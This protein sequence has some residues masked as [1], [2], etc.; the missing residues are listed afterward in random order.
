MNWLYIAGGAAVIVFAFLVTLLST[1]MAALVARRFGFIDIPRLHKAHAKPTPLLGGC[2]IFVAVLGPMLFALALVRVWASTGWPDFIPER[3]AMHIPGA[4]EKAPLAV[5]ILFGALVL[6]V[7][8]IFD[9]R[10]AMGPFLKLTVQVLVAAFVVIVLNVRV[11]TMVDPLTILGLHVGQ[12]LSYIASILWIVTITNAFNFLDNMDG[13]SAGVAAIC[14]A[15]LLAAAASIG[16][17]FVTAWLCLLLGALLGFLV[18]NFPP[19]KIFMGDSGSLVVGY[20]MA[21]LSCLTTYV[22]RNQPYELYAVFVPVVLLA[23]PMYDLLSVICL[24]IKQKRSPFV[25]DRQHFSHRLVKHGM[26]TRLAVLTIY[27][28]TLATAIAATLLPRVDSVGAVLVVVQT[29]AILLAVALLENTDK[30]AP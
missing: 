20:F 4:A 17:V 12:W 30:D 18:Y 29:V 1:P 21:V 19:A 28:V 9:D 24:R 6:H 23:L 5:G 7:M 25:G 16:Q 27:A 10:K 11:L 26:S 3:L 13:L 15:A 14:T 2:A 8:G 22:P